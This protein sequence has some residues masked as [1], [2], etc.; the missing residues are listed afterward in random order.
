MMENN[1][2]LQPNTNQESTVETL[3]VR[4]R[5]L[6]EQLK[7]FQFI[8]WGWLLAALV[9]SGVFIL[10]GVDKQRFTTPN[11]LETFLI[12]RILG[13][14]LFG[15]FGYVYLMFIFRTMFSSRLR[16][17][18]LD[19]VKFGADELKES[20]EENFFTKLVQINFKYLDQYY[21][22]T[23]EQ[24]NKSFGLASIAAA[25]GLII[26]IVGIVMMFNRQTEPAYVTTAAGVLSEFIASI[27]FYLYNKTILKM[28]QYHQKLV[29]T[30]N[31]SLALKITDSMQ[32]DQKAKSLEILVDR[33]TTDANKF[34]TGDE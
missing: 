8:W 9:G 26:V 29:I 33:L 7:S 12:I 34:L 2:T 10:L 17:I 24:A 3:K 23:Q 27:F 5:H 21:L 13:G 11:Q 14:G 19:L 28:S 18:E 6:V 16:R 20:I 15:V 4:Q 31:I 25:V 22:Q 32:D 30:Q 1:Q